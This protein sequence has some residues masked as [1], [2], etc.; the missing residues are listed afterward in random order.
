MAE[1]STD[2][3]ER[4]AALEERL[5]RLEDQQEIARLIASYGP[6]VDSGS[7][8][9][10]ADR[11]EVD[12]TYE[13]DGWS[14][15]GRAEIVA[16]VTGATHQGWIEGGCAHFLGPAHITVEGDEAVA[17]GHSLMVLHN[18][19]EFVVRRATANRWRLRRGPAGWRVTRRTG[20][21]L[22]GREESPRL[23]AALDPGA[24]EAE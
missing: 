23:L 22:D 20:R 9:A 21:V 2:L 10:V 12:G 17:V 14:M 24:V 18:G 3:A 11:W 1:E 16:M 15:N 19:G 5:R 4:L 7:A 6:L 8:E 13:V